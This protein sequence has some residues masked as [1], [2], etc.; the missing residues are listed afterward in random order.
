MKAVQDYMNGKDLPIRM[1]TSEGVFPAETA[2]RYFA[3]QGVLNSPDLARPP[4]RMTD[5][6]IRIV[7]KIADYLNRFRE[8]C[9]L[10][11]VADTTRRFMPLFA[12]KARSKDMKRFLR[13]LLVLSALLIV[14]R[15]GIAY[16][17]TA[18]PGH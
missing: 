1:I 8:R 16:A 7:H 13:G 18:K 2:R 6:L 12:L 15:G 17:A 10:M 11:I 3:R 5:G 9:L 14:F 4:P